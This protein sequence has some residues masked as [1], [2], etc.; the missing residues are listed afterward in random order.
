MLAI[1]AGEHGV[2]CGGVFLRGAAEE[3]RGEGGHDARIGGDG[4]E[5]G[6]ADRPASVER[7]E[8]GHR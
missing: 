7:E 2:V 4:D 6:L 1:D 5:L 3:A 8:T